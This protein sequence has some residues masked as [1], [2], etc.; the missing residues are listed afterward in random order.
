MNI[1]IPAAGKGTRLVPHTL[2]TPKVL[3][4]VA[5]K[6][7]IGH[8]FDRLEPLRPEVVTIIVNPRQAVPV[9]VYLAE[10]YPYPL[11][12]VEQSEP[13]GLG[14][15][16][17]SG[18]LETDDGP[19]VILLGDTIFELDGREMTGSGNRIGVR[20]VDDPRRFGIVEV[21]EGR[22]TAFVE[23]PEQPRSNCAIVGI[24]SI[25][26]TVRLRETL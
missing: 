4:P 7:I 20:S 21:D 5:G 16:V 19:V 1:L 10:H 13:L 15:A 23:K 22:I 12:F 6:P 2:H 11:R 24:Y 9:R 3:L 18:L 14:H 17:L 26:E 25:H 8:I